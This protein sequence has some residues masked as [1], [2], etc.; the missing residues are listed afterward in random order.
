MKE[1]FGRHELAILQFSG[2]KD[3]LATLEMCRP[4]L[5]KII[6]AWVDTGAAFPHVTDFI[7]RAVKRVGANFQVIRPREPQPLSIEKHGFPVDMIPARNTTLG[8]VACKPKV[9]MQSWFECCNRLIWEPMAEFVKGSGATLVI[10]GGKACD[11]IEGGICGKFIDGVEYLCPLD[12]W[13]DEDV[14]KYLNDNN[15]PVSDHFSLVRD[16]LECYSCTATADFTT[17]VVAD[18]ENFLKR[19]YPFVYNQ[20]KRDKLAIANEIIDECRRL[21]KLGE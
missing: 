20:V 13:A 12:K 3:S 5:D 17:D 7:Y 9:K 14:I 21:Y 6:V 1:I 16:S 4:Y 10:G 11:Q 15:V 18:R 8:A 19:Y 2:G